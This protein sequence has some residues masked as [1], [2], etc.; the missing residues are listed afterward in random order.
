MTEIKSYRSEAAAA[1]YETVAGLYD[2][3]LIDDQTLRDFDEPCLT[4]F[5]SLDT[6]AQLVR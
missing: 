5:D 6:E 3:G 2:A 1:I 4:Q